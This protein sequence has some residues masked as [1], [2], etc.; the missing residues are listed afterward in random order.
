MS[1]KLAH[2]DDGKP[3]LCGYLM[4]QGAKGPIR[5]WKKRWFTI[6]KGSQFI[7][8]FRYPKDTEPLGRIDVLSV[9]VAEPCPN[10]LGLRKDRGEFAFQYKTPGR[11]YFLQANGENIVNYWINGIR[12]IRAQLSPKSSESSS[13][14][15]GS[16]GGSPG[17][18]NDSQLTSFNDAPSLLFTPPPNGSDSFTDGQLLVK[19]LEAESLPV[20]AMG[21]QT[22]VY[23]VI[24]FDK[25][26]VKTQVATNFNSIQWN[27]SFFF[28]ITRDDFNK[29]MV[30]SV[31][32][33]VQDMSR[34][35]GSFLGLIYVP[36]VPLFNQPITQ[37]SFPLRASDGSEGT[38]RGKLQISLSFTSSAAEQKVGYDDFEWLR[39]IGK[40]NFGKVVQV[41]KKDTGNAPPF[42]DMS[43]T[44]TLTL[45]TM[46]L[47]KSS[48][49]MSK[50]KDSF[51]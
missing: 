8:Y 14:L 12:D 3:A 9:S 20:N 5:G 10:N 34:N 21:G 1:S 6:A 15:G 46:F 45:R 28:D 39:L 11:T 42:L 26:L 50:K 4:K 29:N 33:W 51:H 36:I 37:Q 38:V 49:V 7:E 18:A 30:L 44:H 31:S 22:G 19:I 43:C 23:C 41:R 48:R 35:G 17:A 25:Q 16:G 40:G 2:S 13:S 24:T 32:V 27:E 47:L